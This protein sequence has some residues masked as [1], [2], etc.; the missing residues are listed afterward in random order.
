MDHLTNLEFYLFQHM[1][2]VFKEFCSAQVAI[3]SHFKDQ[4]C[5][6]LYSLHLYLG[7]LVLTPPTEMISKRGIL[8][9]TTVPLVEL[10]A[11]TMHAVSSP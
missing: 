10:A 9:V 3:L 8:A 5:G 6:Y 7:L 2:W 1:R 11:L 4:L